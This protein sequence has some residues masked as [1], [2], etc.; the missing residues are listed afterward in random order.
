MKKDFTEY[1]NLAAFVGVVVL[2]ILATMGVIGGVTTGNVSHM[3]RSLLTPSDYAFSI[4]GLIYVLVGVMVWRQIKNIGIRDKMGYWFFAS[5][6][7]NAA[8]IF[9]WQ[10]KAIGLSFILIF[11]LLL[12]LLMLMKSMKDSDTLSKMAVGMYAGWVNVAMLANLGTVFSRYNWVLLGLS[13]KVWAVIG[14]AFGLLWIGYFLFSY[15]NIYYAIAACWGYLGIVTA[16]AFQGIKIMGIVS[17]VVLAGSIIL[18]L[19]QK[20]SIDVEAKY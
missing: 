9:A 19:M 13:G 20:K 15:S 4:W 10:F 16:S 17:M 11:A 12:V 6:I 14:L 5:C 3:Y 18:V 8:W 1:G 2:N 7:L